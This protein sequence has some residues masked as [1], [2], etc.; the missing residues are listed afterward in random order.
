MSE[1]AI[2]VYTDGSVRL[3][4]PIRVGDMLRAAD[5]LRQAVEGITINPPSPEKSSSEAAP[6]GT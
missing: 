6:E 2:E 4:K 3:V 1:V 5:T